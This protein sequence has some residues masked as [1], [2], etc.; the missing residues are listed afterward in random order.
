MKILMINHTL[1]YYAG[2]ETFTYTLAVELQREGHEIICFSPKLGPLAERIRKK[3]IEVTD[4]LSTIDTDIDVIHA[5]HR[6]E[7]LIAYTRFAD[8]PIILVCHGI[9]P[10][11]EQPPMSRLNI[12]RYVAVSEEVRNHLIHN[13]HIDPNEIEIIRNSID[14]TR[15]YCKQPIHSVPKSAIIVSNYMTEQ[16]RLLIRKVCERLN[17]RVNLV[18]FI[19]KSV[20]DIEEHINQADIV[21]ALGRSALEAMA[22]RRVVIVYDYNGADGIV[23]PENYYLLRKKNFSGRTNNFQYNEEKLLREIEKYSQTIPDEIFK[24]IEKEHNIRNIAKQFIDLYIRAIN[25]YAKN[26]I[27]PQQIYLNQ[28]LALREILSSTDTRAILNL[29]ETSSSLENQVKNYQ[30]SIRQKDEQIRQKDEQIRFFLNS[31][32][33]KI[34]RPLRKIYD[35]VFRKSTL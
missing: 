6:H 14:L 15:F 34:T 23:T 16:Q 26:K 2:S 22:C 30:E 27:R 28:Y 13:H 8:K 5:H 25:Y 17:I 3:G 21:F 18:G 19:D 35:L 9:L 10:W 29:K 12:Y 4:D 33:W 1:D 32:S 7:T 24:F 31:R 20:W 11:Q